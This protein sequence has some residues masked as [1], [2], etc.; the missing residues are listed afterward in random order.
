MDRFEKLR[1]KILPVLLPYVKRVAVFGSFA[2]GEGTSESDIDIFSPVRADY[3]EK[4]EKQGT[5]EVI[6]PK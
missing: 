1:D 3:I 2:R 4:T 5:Y 6:I